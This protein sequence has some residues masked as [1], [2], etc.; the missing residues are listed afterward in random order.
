MAQ[1]TGAAQLRQLLA[2]EK[3]EEVEDPYGNTVGNKWVEQSKHPAAV[4]ARRGGEAVIAGRLQGTV[5]Y[6]VTV[7][8]STS[9]AAITTDHRFR[10]L[11]S[12]ATYNIR[13]VIARPRRDYIDFDV[14]LGVAD[15]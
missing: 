7:R 15:G 14:E 2:A 4:E 6:I 5:A 8:H 11:R 12:G 9:A 1:T 10:D 13:T 3:R